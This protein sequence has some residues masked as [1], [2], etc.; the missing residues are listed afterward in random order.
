MPFGHEITIQQKLNEL[1][2]EMALRRN[3]YP[4]MIRSG[5]MTQTH[6]DRHM[7][8]LAAIIADYEKLQQDEEPKLL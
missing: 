4:G 7:A 2:R 1:R 8:V 5:R 3:V 6:A